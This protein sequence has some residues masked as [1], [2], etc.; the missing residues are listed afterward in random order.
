LFVVAVHAYAAALPEGVLVIHSNQ[1][2]TPAAIIIED[3]LR[4][5][6][7]DGLKRP[8][9]LYSEYLDIERFPVDTYAVAGA[10][11]LRQK[12]HDRNIRVIVASAPQAVAFA[13]KFRERIVPGL[14]VVHIAMPRDQMERMSL[15]PDVVGKTIDLD[16]KQT[17]ELA[18][19]LHPDAKRLM[20][21]VGAAERDRLWEQR[22][23]G[24][25][26]RLE[27]PLPVEYLSGLATPYVLNRLKELDKETIVFTPGYFID[28]AGEVAT[29]RQTVE[30]IAAA[31]A[32]P[33]YG[34]LDTFLG[35]G[36]VG[37][38]MAPYEE[39]AKQAASLVVLLLNGTAPAAI[40]PMPIKNVPVVDWRA[41]RHWGI[42]ERLL[43]AATIVRFR[44]P[45]AGDRY[46]REI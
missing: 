33:V 35:T 36:I 7:P 18:F 2:P 43:P 41:V 3:T 45:T 12:Y 39:Q 4:K 9:E 19:R 11:F 23:R 25:V 30:L 5:A 24:A 21:I 1:R 22:V 31:S 6:V 13:T 46:G 42:D 10:E 29:P 40:A 32:A 20:V 26:A 17:L 37:G 38:Y 44:E 28:G 16:P 27:R 8:V 34:P 14:P 15:P